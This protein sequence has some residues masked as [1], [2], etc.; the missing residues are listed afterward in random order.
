MKATFR[1]QRMLSPEGLNNS[2][3]SASTRRC[4]RRICCTF[5]ELRTER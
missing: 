5:N 1:G 4:N 2:A 3:F